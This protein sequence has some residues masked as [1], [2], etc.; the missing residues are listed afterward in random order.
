MALPP[1]PSPPP[2]SPPH[3]ADPRRKRAFLVGGVLLAAI[4]L[5][6][7]DEIWDDDD[8]SVEITIGDEESDE[9]RNAVRERIRNN[10]RGEGGDLGEE[11]EAMR[12]E[13]RGVV[14]DAEAPDAPPA[15]EADSD[16]PEATAEPAAES[17]DEP[18]GG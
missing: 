14:E 9:I 13:I 7:A 12:E 4:V 16:E 18:A 15:P 10:V 2:G 1:E 17:E 6:N 3:E 5:W 11:I 8:H